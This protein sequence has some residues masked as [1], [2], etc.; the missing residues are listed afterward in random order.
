MIVA[1]ISEAATTNSLI[2]Q[3][4]KAYLDDNYYKALELYLDAQKKE[5]TS[6]DLYYNIGNCYYR[7]KDNGKAIL[8][9]ERALNLNPNNKEARN[10]IELVKTKLIDKTDIDDTNIIGQIFRD[11]GNTATSNNWA[12]WSV[13]FFILFLSALALYIFATS[14]LA[15]KFGFFGGMIL[16]ICMVVTLAYSISL[17]DKATNGQYAIIV[18]PSVTIS[19][20]PRTPKD[21]SEEAFLLNQGTKIVILDSIDNNMGKLKERWYEIKADNNHRGW[22]NKKNIEII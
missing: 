10:N 1:F 5:G 21:K 11:F 17:K 13:A 9:Y 18:S 12:V 22:I 8:Y 2:D 15:K 4:N 6:S 20:S 19:T 14:V 3:A 7:L 16:L